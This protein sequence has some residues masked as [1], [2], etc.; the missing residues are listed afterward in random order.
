MIVCLTPPSAIGNFD[1]YPRQ[2]KSGHLLVIIHGFL[3]PK[4]GFFDIWN[5]MVC[6]FHHTPICL[7]CLMFAEPLALLDEKKECFIR[8]KHALNTAYKKA[9]KTWINV[10]LKYVMI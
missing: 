4:S 6:Y 9:I 3:E 5:E 1:L 10:C 8:K 7:N 2:W